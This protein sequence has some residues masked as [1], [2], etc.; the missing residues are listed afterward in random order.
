LAADG[1]PPIGK[2]EIKA[3]RVFHVNG[4]PFFPL[5]SWLQDAENFPAVKACGMNATAGYWPGTGGTKDGVE[6]LE[7]VQEAGLYGVMPFDPRL[8]AH[9]YLLGYIHDDEPDLPRQV[10]DAETVPG[11]GL[12]IN[13]KTPLW[14]LVDGVTHTWSVLDPLE[15]AAVTIRLKR[16]VTVES[17]AV[18]LT[19]S[20]GISVAKD[21]AF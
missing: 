18:W 6:Y 16:P 14:K 15:G 5:M 13:R 11:A 10:S 3:N 21:V 7:L 20:K 1:P 2:V 12:R 19:I 17:V 4:E 9:P 8:K